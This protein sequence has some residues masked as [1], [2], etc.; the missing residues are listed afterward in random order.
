MPTL[1]DP[2]MRPALFQPSPDPQHEALRRRTIAIVLTILAHALL[3]LML[4]RLAPEQFRLP[5]APQLKTFSLMPES[6]A[7]EKRTA[8]VDRAQRRSGGA[9]K[10]PPPPREVQQPTVPPP[11]PAPPLN[12]IPLSRQDMAV[13][14]LSRLHSDVGERASGQGQATGAGSGP[15]SGAV[16]GPSLGGG[17][18]GEQLYNAEWYREPTDAELAFYLP[19]TGGPRIGSAM[20]ACQTVERYHVDNCRELGDSPPGTGLA[21]AIRQAAWQ[22]LVRP[23]RVGG[24]VMVGAWV[25]IRIDFT[26]KGIK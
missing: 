26:E 18:G 23:P 16:Y 7:A 11:T 6:T 20:I 15:D 5:E 3:L 14:D 1:G 4:L 2:P 25:R 13:A 8:T 17:S 12:I 22:F 9:P 21:R 24:K 10:Q 19:K